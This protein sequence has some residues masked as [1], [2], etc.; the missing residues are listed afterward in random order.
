M[1][2]SGADYLTQ[3]IDATQSTL[4]DIIGTYYQQEA[5]KKATRAQLAGAQQAG[6]TATRYAGQAAGYYQPF[7]DAG[8]T[9][10]NRLNEMLDSGAFENPD[11]AAGAPDYGT[12][13][14]PEFNFQ[15]DP[16]YAFR[17][18][19]GQRAIE[20]S[21]AAR[22]S[23]LSGATQKALSQY[24]QQLASNEYSNAYNRYM[25]ER[26]QGFGEY[27]NMRNF[28]FNK[29]NVGYQANAANTANRYNRLS[30]AA[31]MGY[32]AGGQLSNISGNLGDTLSSLD[33][34]RGDIRAGKEV[35]LGNL[36]ANRWANQGQIN[37]NFIQNTGGGGQTN[38]NNVASLGSVMDVA[39]TASNYGSSGQGDDTELQNLLNNVQNP[40]N[41]SRTGSYDWMQYIG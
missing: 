2:G 14:A 12:Y 17:Q 21:A 40:Q 36:A 23:A 9:Q 7:Y 4:T 38:S 18:Q 35:A 3:G 29:Y 13:T 30:S 1:A 28:L 25:S 26:Q 8:L 32:N 15:T 27:S 16:G 24:S 31:N 11:Y 37:S 10:W 39:G 20:S 22:G 5:A 33:L 6:E 41:D 19:E 34:R